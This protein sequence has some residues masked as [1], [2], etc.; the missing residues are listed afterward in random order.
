MPSNSGSEIEQGFIDQKVDVKTYWNEVV[1]PRLAD[2][3]RLPTEHEAI[4]VEKALNRLR[5]GF[6]MC[7]QDTLMH[8]QTQTQASASEEFLQVLGVSS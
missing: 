4:R 6:M 2:L 1:V 5:S 7:C 8:T 3:Q